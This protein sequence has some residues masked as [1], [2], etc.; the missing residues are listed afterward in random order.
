M[1]A[2]ISSIWFEL[3][4]TIRNWM[5]N[6]LASVDQGTQGLSEEIVVKVEETQLGLQTVMTSFD[7][8]TKKLQGIQHGDPRGRN[9]HAKDEDPNRSHAVWT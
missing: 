5:E 1:E 2:A 8:H 9:R 4:E 3:E 7:M 6:V